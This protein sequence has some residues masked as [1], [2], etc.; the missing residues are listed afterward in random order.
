MTEHILITAVDE[1]GVLHTSLQGSIGEDRLNVLE[2]DVETA[3]AM[4]LAYYQKHGAKLRSLIDLTGFDGTYVPKAIA[5][6]ATYMKSNTQFVSQS[7]AFGGQDS[8]TLA[9]NIIASIAG[10]DN[11]KFFKTREEAEAWLSKDS[12]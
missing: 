9:A 5:I 12:S 1:A 3:K 8:T 11:L 6:L 2:Q 10:R 4:V 7:A